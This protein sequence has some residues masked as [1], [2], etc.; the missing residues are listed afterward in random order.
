M[1]EQSRGLVLRFLGVGS[2]QA[3]ELGASS[4]VLEQDGRPLLLIDAGPGV[5]DRYHARYGSLPDAMFLTHPHSDHIGDFEHWFYRLAFVDAPLPRLYFPAP[6]VRWMQKRVA[7]FPNWVAEGGRN[8]WDVFH[9]IP[10]DEHFWHA[11]WRFEVF[12]VRHHAPD[13]AYGLALAGA[14]AYSGD[15]RPV[16]EQLARHAGRGERVFHDC[17]V[18]GNPSHTGLDDLAREYPDG[19]RARMVLYH[20]PDDEAAAAMRQAG[21]EVAKAGKAYPLPE[22]ADEARGPWARPESD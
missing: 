17:T 1:V 3:V 10:V 21:Y 13:A 5:L 14:F 12:P 6:L 20:Y 8:F 11:G 7:S 4:A 9:L 19:L 15:T 22:P 18:E 2:A 16:P